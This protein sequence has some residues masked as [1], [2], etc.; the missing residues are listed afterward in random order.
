[1]KAYKIYFSAVL[2]FVI[3]LLFGSCNGAKETNTKQITVT[4]PPLQGIVK[5]VVGDDFDINILLPEGSSPET[6]SPTINQVAELEDSEF[7]FYVGTLPFENELISRIQ[8]AKGIN[9]SNGVKLLTGDEPHN[10]SHENHHHHHTIDPHIWFS[11]YELST[12]VDNIDTALMKSYPD[13]LKYHTNCQAIKTKLEVNNHRY[14]QLLKDSPKSFLIYHPAL[15][16]L[17]N[18]LGMNQIALENE[19]KS[20]TPAALAGI[21]DL[22]KKENIKVMLYQKEY[23]LDT[24]QPIADILNVKLVEINPLSTDII[25]EIDRVINILCGDY[26]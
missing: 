9:V 19:G 6:Y 17:A 3:G 25:G 20:P 15:G 11:I 14:Q 24:V 7:V 12:I 23:P 21:V 1:M 10:H 5:E 18:S 16:Y 13:S 26:E 4:I 8:N 22:V 2:L